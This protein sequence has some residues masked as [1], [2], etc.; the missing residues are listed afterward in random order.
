MG[1]GLRRSVGVGEG[2]DDGFEGRE[3]A[4]VVMMRRSE[5]LTHQEKGRSLLP[6]EGEG[7]RGLRGLMGSLL[8]SRWDCG[9]YPGLSPESSR[10]TSCRMRGRARAT[11]L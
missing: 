10:A 8:G 6:L 2:K 9:P 1:A 11:L 4:C 3:Q 5:F 7:R